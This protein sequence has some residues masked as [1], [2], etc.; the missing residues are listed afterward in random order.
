MMTYILDILLSQNEE[1]KLRYLLLLIADS[2]K[3]VDYLVSSRTKS[4]Y[5]DDLA[6]YCFSL[7]F[8]L[9]EKERRYS[10]PRLVRVV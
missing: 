2:A 10:H 7:R 1:N 3:K 4:L 9:K 6:T 8:C 5:V